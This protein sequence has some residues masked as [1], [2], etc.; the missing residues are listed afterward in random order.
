MIE[1]V[2]VMV[3]MAIA[4]AIVLPNIRGMIS[5]TQ[6]S[7]YH[8]YCVEATSYVRS[9]ANMLSLG[10]QTVPYEKNGKTYNYTITNPSGLTNALNEYNLESTYRYYVLAYAP[11]SAKSNPTSTIMSLISNKT[12]PN[13]DVM[14]TVIVPE[15]AGGRVPKYVLRG[16]WYYNADQQTVVYSFYVS[17]KRAT[18]GFKKLTSDGK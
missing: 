8:N 11:E 1:L 6:E 10:E 13:K 15:D 12:I 9:Y 16:F 2:A 3:V 14:V 18:V 7:T 17:S 5:N 4:T